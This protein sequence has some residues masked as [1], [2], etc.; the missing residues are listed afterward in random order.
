LNKIYTLRYLINFFLLFTVIANYDAKAQFQILN[1]GI[2]IHAVQNLKVSNN[3]HIIF[4]T[5]N[6]ILIYYAGSWTHF[7][8]SNGL[9]T[10]DIKGISP[11]SGG[12]LYSGAGK[13]IGYCNYLTATDSIFPVSATFSY[14]N[15]IYYSTADNLIFFG[16][17]NGDTWA[18][19][20]TGIHHLAF[21][22]TFG[23]TLGSVSD[24]N[25]MSGTVNFYVFSTTNQIMLYQLSSGSAVLINSATSPL[26]SNNVIS[27]AVSGSISYDGTDKGM[28]I[29]NFTAFPT[30]TTSIIN[31]TNTP[32]PSDTIKA[33][34][35]K[36]GNIFIGTPMG[37]AVRINNNWKIYTTANSNLP[38]SDIAKLAIDS[39][40]LWIGTAAGGICKIGI[41]TIITAINN[42][43]PRNKTCSIYPNPV[44]D[45]LIVE[46]GTLGANI[47]IYSLPGELVY[48]GTINSNK[49]IIN[50]YGFTSGTYII[51]LVKSNGEKEKK[52]I[53]KQ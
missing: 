36:G 50:V 51:E 22:S 29:A 2:T 46:N 18:Q 42:E 9:S 37:L 20:A 27:N 4:A 39:N 10:L 14:I 26:P 17:D 48:N 12:F 5:D 31:K 30:V 44:T 38:S 34:A 33:V 8:L 19:N 28:Y 24:I 21:D 3:Q 16:S 7:D 49:E 13:K 35:I 47:S 6:G 40:D 11:N 23:I 52:I 1:P 25:Q 32:I 15:A 41:D 43:E 45:Q 53:T